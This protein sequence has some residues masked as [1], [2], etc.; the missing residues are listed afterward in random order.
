MDRVLL[1]LL[2]FIFIFVIVF[3]VTIPC[4]ASSSTD[5]PSAKFISLCDNLFTNSNCTRI[6]NSNGVDITE[7]FCK[8]YY[9][10]YNYYLLWESV[11]ENEYTISWDN[12][13]S[14]MVPQLVMSGTLNK[15]FYRI[16]K[17][18]TFPIPKTFEVGFS[19][20]CSYKYHDS[21]GQISWYG[22]TVL[23]DVTANPG[24]LFPYSIDYVVTDSYLSNNSRT[25]NIGAAFN[26]V[27]QYSAGEIPGIT[28][29]EESFPLS[30]DA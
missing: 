13:K 14:E 18:I 17:T 15:N 22:P 25:L 3:N 7:Y 4:S 27:V 5:E 24:A 30:G 28:Y 23:Y 26:L 12:L 9:T 2:S 6:S 11:L 29:W 8:T 21:T 10:E 16:V 1:K 20:T 19:I